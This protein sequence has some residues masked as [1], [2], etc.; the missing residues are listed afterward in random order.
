LWPRLSPL[1]VI[2]IRIVSA[3]PEPA[4]CAG[5]AAYRHAQG[6]RSRRIRDSVHAISIICLEFA[7]LSSGDYDDAF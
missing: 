1:A 2:S 7:S 3:P 6:R 4:C 5:G